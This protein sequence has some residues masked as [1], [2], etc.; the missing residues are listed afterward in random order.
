VVRSGAS[1]VRGPRVALVLGAA[2]MVA[3]TAFAVVAGAPSSAATAP[4]AG[5]EVRTQVVN[6][7]GTTS[8]SIYRAAEGVTAD[9]LYA[10]RYFVDGTV[11]IR[12]NHNYSSSDD[13]RGTVCQNIGHALGVGH[14]SSTSSCMYPYAISGPDPRYPNSADYGLIRYVLYPD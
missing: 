2:A 6:A 1:I 12:L 11:G 10:A 13:N 7:D 14:N 8:V 5:A 3:V 9:A 4:P